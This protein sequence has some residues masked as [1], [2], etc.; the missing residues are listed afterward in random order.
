MDDVFL[1]ILNMSITASWLL[2]AVFLAR[3][4]LKK[5]P[6]R[7]TFLFWAM[8]AIRLIFPFS[9]PS[10]FSLIPS[11]ETIPAGIALM[12]RPAIASG[13][14]I[15]NQAINPIIADT[16]TPEATASANP[17]QIVIPLAAIVWVA[18]IAVMLLYALISYLRLKKTVAASLP[19]QDAAGRIMVCDEIAS[20]FIL[21]IFRP[22]I[23]VPSSM[24][25]E[26]L[27]Y[28]IAHENAHQ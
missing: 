19:L 2:P 9:L 7:M 8:A 6:K 3:L 22:A 1:K 10:I 25:G 18:G 14:P 21:G 13:I 28:V 12:H 27:D 5:A 16:F 23:Y 24:G 4:L 15:V 20:P 11:A 17:L 26:T